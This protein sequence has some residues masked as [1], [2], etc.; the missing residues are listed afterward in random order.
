MMFQVSKST[1]GQGLSQICKGKAKYLIGVILDPVLAACKFWFY[2]IFDEYKNI[3]GGSLG[4]SINVGKL[5]WV[6]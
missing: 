6:N 3:L 4:G 5:I 2:E 1:S